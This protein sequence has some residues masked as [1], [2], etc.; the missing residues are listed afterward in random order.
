MLDIESDFLLGDVLLLEY[1]KDCI[2]NH[3]SG[4][5]PAVSEHLIL[6]RAL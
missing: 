6:K 4:Y 2:L 1:C 3:F 5:G